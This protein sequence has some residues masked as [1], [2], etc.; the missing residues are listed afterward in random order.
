MSAS[1]DSRR[2]GRR[3][4]PSPRAGLAPCAPGGAA[5]NRRGPTRGENSR[6]FLFPGVEVDHAADSAP[7]RSAEG[8]LVAREHDAVGLR[9]E[10][11]LRLVERALEGADLARVGASRKQSGLVRLLFLEERIHLPLGAVGGA[12]RATA[13]LEIS[14][15]L[16]EFL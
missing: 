7:A 15:V 5:R 12:D 9:A 4:G 16:F 10:I 6:R 11:A 2:A 1:A 3:G 8:N 14:R 13:R